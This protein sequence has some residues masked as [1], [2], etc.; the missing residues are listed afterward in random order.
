MLEYVFSKI[1]ELL[2]ND[3]MIK[4]IVANVNKERTN[5]INPAKKE[6]EKI[7]KELEKLDKKKKKIFEAY[8]DELITKDEF[9][10]RKEELNSRVKTF[11]E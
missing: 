1:S 2:A 5:K 10:A 4:A 8:E 11:E 9:L 7:D 6:V 3:K